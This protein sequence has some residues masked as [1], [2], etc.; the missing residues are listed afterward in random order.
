MENLYKKVIFSCQ[1]PRYNVTK[2]KVPY[3]VVRKNNCFSKGCPLSGGGMRHPEGSLSRTGYM[4][5]EEDVRKFGKW[6]SSAMRAKSV[7]FTAEIEDIKPVFEMIE[8]KGRNRCGLKISGSSVRLKSPLINT[9]LFMGEVSL[10]LDE[11]VTYFF[12]QG[13]T[14][15]G[16][17]KL[18]CQENGMFFLDSVPDVRTV[19]SSSDA[20]GGVTFAPPRSQLRYT[21]PLAENICEDCKHSVLVKNE[22]RDKLFSGKKSVYMTFCQSSHCILELE[23]IYPGVSPLGAYE[24]PLD[25]G[26]VSVEELEL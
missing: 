13:D 21:N 1:H 17:G 3:W 11:G 24:K 5:F 7:T 14:V 8:V 19:L 6:V 4:L 10:I 18:H 26:D 16:S 22:Y 20:D 15:S 12:S 25:G 23:G 9:D 2:G